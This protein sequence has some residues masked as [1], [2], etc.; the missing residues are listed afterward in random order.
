[1]KK[2][3]FI[4]ALLAFTLLLGV[5]PAAAVKGLSEPTGDAPELATMSIGDISVGDYVLFGKYEQD[6]I[7]NN[8]KEDIEWR[9]LYVDTN[10]NSVL[11]IS[12]YALDTQRFNNADKNITWELS[13]IRAWLNSTFFDAAFSKSEKDA[14]A[15]APIMAE[16]NPK[17]S[18][19]PGNGT[20]DNVFLLSVV[21]AEEYFETDYDRMCLPTAYAIANGTWTSDKYTSG[22][23]VSCWYWTRTPGYDG[24]QAAGVST[25]GEIKYGGNNVALNG[26]A[27][28]PAIWV[29]VNG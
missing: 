16:Y 3:V 10:D 27:V 15:L 1:M 4:A 25:N 29:Y 11:L 17:Y 28:R 26:Y 18:T 23:E 13:P 24:H 8:G 2:T 12:K 7:K 19:K 20:M 6:N 5:I 14:I 9:V 21:E 22:G